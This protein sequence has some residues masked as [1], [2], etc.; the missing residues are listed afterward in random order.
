MLWGQF[1]TLK[2]VLRK[3]TPIFLLLWKWE[4]YVF[5]TEKKPGVKSTVSLLSI[6][7]YCL[8][9]GRTQLPATPEQ[10][11]SEKSMV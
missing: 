11:P 9:C 3:N 10:A 2:I 6:S 8:A 5:K 4:E 1:E 7:D